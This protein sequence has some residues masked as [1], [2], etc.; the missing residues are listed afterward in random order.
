MY[1]THFR[2]ARNY[3]D[4]TAFE[5]SKGKVKD[6]VA[7]DIIAP[8]G[9]ALLIEV[10][11]S[12]DEKGRT[13]MNASDL[14]GLWYHGRYPANYQPHRVTFE[15]SLDDTFVIRP[16]VTIVMACLQCYCCLKQSLK[17]KKAEEQ[18]NLLVEEGPKQGEEGSML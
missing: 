13:F 15:D 2:D 14:E 4:E 16:G 9:T 6:F 11:S 5:S 18:K 12:L 10:F 7:G 17:E 1:L 3:F 8:Y